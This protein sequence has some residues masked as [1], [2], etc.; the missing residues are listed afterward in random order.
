[1]DEG[2]EQKFQVQVANHSDSTLL[3]LNPNEYVSGF[4]IRRFCVTRRSGMMQQ[5]LRGNDLFWQ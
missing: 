4:C 1:M 2:L 5:E 3:E